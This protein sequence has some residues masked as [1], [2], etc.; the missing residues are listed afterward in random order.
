M[1]IIQYKNVYLGIYSFVDR[2]IKN[3]EKNSDLNTFLNIMFG[4]TSSKMYYMVITKKILQM[5]RIWEIF[6]NV[7]KKGSQ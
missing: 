2:H 1:V 4:Q 7:L 5:F 6:V 3:I